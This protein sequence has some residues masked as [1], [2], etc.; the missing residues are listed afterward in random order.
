MTTHRNLPKP[1]RRSCLRALLASGSALFL[2]RRGLAAESA[3]PKVLTLYFTW[4]GGSEVVAREV[5]RLLGGTIARIETV[6]PYPAEYK[7]TTRV[8][9]REFEEDARPAIRPVPPLEEADVIVLCHAIWSGRMPRALFTLLEGRNLA[10]KT[11]LHA[12][13]HGG[14]GLAQSQKELVDLLPGARVLPGLAVYGWGGV[15]SVAEV[16]PW[17]ER[18]GVLQNAQ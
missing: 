13:T 18:C 15:R 12:V 4:S 17:L 11:I 16:R 2:S 1:G 9:I 7:P 14:S 8:A 3:S 5:R 10:G 6:T